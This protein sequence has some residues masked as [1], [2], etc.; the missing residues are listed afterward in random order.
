MVKMFVKPREREGKEEQEKSKR[1]QTYMNAGT[2]FFFLTISTGFNLQ[3]RV[4]AL[5]R[6]NPHQWS[7]DTNDTNWTRS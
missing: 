4:C 5:Q 7:K 6:P 3:G 1:C 2:F